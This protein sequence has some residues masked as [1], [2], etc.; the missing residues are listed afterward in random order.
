M[1][2]QVAFDPVGSIKM[3]LRSPLEGLINIYEIK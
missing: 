1:C 2:L 3:M